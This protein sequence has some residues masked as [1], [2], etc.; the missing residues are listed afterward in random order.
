M[1]G[2]ECRKIFER[3]TC[4]VVAAAVL[5][6]LLPAPVS[7]GAAPESASRIMVI[8][9]DTNGDPADAF[10]GTLLLR[11]SGGDVVYLDGH[12]KRGLDSGLLVSTVEPGR[13]ELVGVFPDEVARRNERLLSI[14]LPFVLRPGTDLLLPI[15][16][17]VWEAENDSARATRIG[18][19][20]ISEAEVETG[21]REWYSA[22]E[23]VSRR[24]GREPVFGTLSR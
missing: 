17:T 23:R 21:F 22:A 7:A 10:Y 18:V 6:V 19:R 5:A 4:M 20:S 3:R 16:V 2:F 12:D 24:S 9:S 13:W 11:D 1:K 15:V 14:R 8:V